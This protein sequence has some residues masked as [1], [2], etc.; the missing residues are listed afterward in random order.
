[1]LSIKEFYSVLKLRKKGV[2][3]N[4]IGWVNPGRAHGEIAV[5]NL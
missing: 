5:Y 3:I 1:M 2:N 4:K